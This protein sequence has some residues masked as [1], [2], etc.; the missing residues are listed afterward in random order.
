[1]NIFDSILK[2]AVEETEEK[3]GAFSS[4]EEPAPTEEPKE[5]EVIEEPTEP[6][7][8]PE[9]TVVEDEDTP[10]SQLRDICFNILDIM[11]NEALVDG[12]V[13]DEDESVD[14]STEILAK[15]ADKFDD[16]TC[17]EIIKILSDYFEIET[18]IGEEPD[19]EYYEEPPTKEDE[20]AFEEDKLPEEAGGAF[21]K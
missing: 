17:L 1:M 3:K 10:Q 14:I 12:E 18:E 11:E 6:T 4:E 13:A 20:T 9:E 16:A 7:E 15:Y 8:E 5:E 2:E 19:E 21:S